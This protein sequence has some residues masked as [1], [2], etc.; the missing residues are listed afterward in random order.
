M[1]TNDHRLLKKPDCQIHRQGN[2]L[3]SLAIG[4]E[5]RRERRLP[6][7]YPLLPKEI[8]ET[9]AHYKSRGGSFSDHVISDHMLVAI[10]KTNQLTSTLLDF[11]EHHPKKKIK[12]APLKKILQ[13]K[14]HPVVYN[15]RPSS[16]SQKEIIALHSISSKVSKSI[17]RRTPCVHSPYV[18]R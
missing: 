4:S 5:Q 10:H 2:I 18:Y 13:T 3:S 7:R 17:K 16:E 8:E 9:Q 11:Q 14:D 1:E 15:K 6:L 12:Q